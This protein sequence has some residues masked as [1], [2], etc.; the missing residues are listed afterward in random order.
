MEN[1]IIQE[2]NKSAEY[3]QPEWIKIILKLL[4]KQEK[5]QSVKKC[6]IETFK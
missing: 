3:E 6:P 4:E 5:I 2:L 1:N